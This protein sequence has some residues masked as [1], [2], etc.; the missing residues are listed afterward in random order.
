MPADSHGVHRTAIVLDAACFHVLLLVVAMR[1]LL[2][3][4]YSYEQPNVLRV[5]DQKGNLTPLATAAFDLV[6]WLAAVGAT[7]ASAVRGHRWRWTGLEVGWVILIGAAFVSTWSADNR[8]VAITASAD[9][10]T[11]GAL[12]MVLA[13]LCRNRQRMLLLLGVIVASGAAAAVRCG[14]QVGIEFGE[15]RNQYLAIKPEFWQQQGIALDDPQVE[16]YERRMNAREA[17]GFLSFSNAQAHGLTLA[18]FAALGA[19]CL[20][21]RRW[22][23]ALVP[24]TFASSLLLILPAT[25]SRGGMVGAAVGVIGFLLLVWQESRLR[26]HWRR[27]LTVGWLIVLLAGVGTVG[28]GLARG[29]LPGASLNFRWQ[30]WKVTAQILREHAWTGVGAMNFD[31][32]YLRHKPIEYPEEIKDPH[33]FILSIAAQ[34]GLPGLFGF[35]TAL[36][37]ASWVGLRRWHDSTQLSEN[38][39]S[40]LNGFGRWLIGLIV[41]FFALRVWLLKEYLG[42]DSADLAYVIFDLGVYGLAWAVTLALLVMTAGRAGLAGSPFIPVCCG[43]LVFLAQNT[44]D[45]SLFVAGTLYP[46][47]ALAGVALART[48]Q[49]PDRADPGRPG[50]LPRLAAIAGLL[51]FWAAVYRPVSQ[52]HGPLMVARACASHASADNAALDCALG[53]YGRAADFDRLDPTALIE[54]ADLP[55]PASADLVRVDQSLAAVEEAIR[56]VPTRVSS[57]RS[58]MVLRLWRYQASR[59]PADL[60]AARSAGFKA[61]ELFPNSPDD[62]AAMGD[63]LSEMARELGPRPWLDEAVYHYQRSL[64]LDAARPGL[65]EVRRWPVSRR[66]SVAQRLRSLQE[67]FPASTNPG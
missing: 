37:G 49:E 12:I 64:D 9:W 61:I 17:S 11:A 27:V 6:V 62:H 30:Y 14:M 35:F 52:V 13:N 46:L 56:R 19:G 24:L 53:A 60:L 59:S 55:L 28:Y 65:D 34:W 45:F 26:R 29:G 48:H 20:L 54:L 33:N 31:A 44:I 58:Q 38:E 50:Y 2:T 5:L 42:G 15:T 57:Y 32:A 16:L 36:M 47:A 51:V 21:A 7:I 23:F 66:N 39:S 8:R 25:G 18:L 67:S 1:P 22:P 43:L 40:V 63:L 4:T 41:G 3:E 10:L